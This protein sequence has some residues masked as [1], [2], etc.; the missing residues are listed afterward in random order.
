MGQLDGRIAIVTGGSSGIG[1]AISLLFA[2]EGAT[3]VI[4]D[5]SDEAIGGGQPTLELI[6]GAGHE[7]TFAR[8]D[9]GV[10]ADIDALVARTID[11]FGRID[12]LVNNAATYVGKPLLETSE[13]EWN[14]VFAVNVTGVFLLTRAV[15][16]QMLKQ[17]SRDGV[18]G[19]IVNITSQHGMIAAPR[20][21]AYGTSKSAIVYMTR[22]IAADYA[23]E[24]I[25]CNALAPG[26]IVTG[27]GGREDDPYWVEYWRSRTPL[28]RF[29]VPD[30]VARAALY[31]ASDAATFITGVNLMVDGGWSAS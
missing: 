15:V 6:R 30:D 3:T 22:Q 5:V 16:F 26:K 13:E 7:G 14:R 29:G 28:P 4:A 17:E 20:D 21:I 23:T 19:R 18:R 10:P 24:G 31:L 2:A 9:M 27:K 12:I 11:E 8:A 25:V 1:R